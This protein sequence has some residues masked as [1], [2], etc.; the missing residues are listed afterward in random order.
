MPLLLRWSLFSLFFRAFFVACLWDRFD[1]WPPRSSFTDFALCSVLRSIRRLFL[2]W[3]LRSFFLVP[4]PSCLFFAQTTTT[5]H[6]L[7][8]NYFSSSSWI[9]VV[10]LGEDP[11]H[12]SLCALFALSWFSSAAVSSSHLRAWTPLPQMKILSFDLS[13]LVALHLPFAS[14][15]SCHFLKQPRHEPK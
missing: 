1:A 3:T 7:R 11:Q 9:G 8:S 15:A 13:L 10:S 14:Q 4:A 12:S 5:S 2:T 6:H